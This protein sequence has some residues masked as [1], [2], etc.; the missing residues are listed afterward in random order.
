M[1][2]VGRETLDLAITMDGLSGT[3]GHCP[4]PSPPARECVATRDEGVA[5]IRFL[6]SA[7]YGHIDVDPAVAAQLHATAARLREAGAIVEEGGFSTEASWPWFLAFMRADA[8]YE[9][10]S[11]CFPN[12]PAFVESCL[13]PETF[14]R[15][16]IGRAHV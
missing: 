8:I 11:P 1:G 9:N 3:D 2:R 10:A 14:V 4:R 7:D 12:H 15:L 16:E 5:G 6:W 13:A